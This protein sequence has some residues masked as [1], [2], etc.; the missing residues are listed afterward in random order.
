MFVGGSNMKRREANYLDTKKRVNPLK[1]IGIIAAILL[2]V[3]IVIYARDYNKNEEK[4]HRTI[5]DVL[6]AV[7]HP[8]NIEG[9]ETTTSTDG[10][11]TTTTTEPETTQD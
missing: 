4:R 1:V 2:V 10:T 11:Q 6:Y 3:G 9:A 7:E 5:E 8:T